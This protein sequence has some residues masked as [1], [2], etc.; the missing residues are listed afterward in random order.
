MLV[1]R[2]D[3]SIDDVVQLTTNNLTFSIEAH[4]EPPELKG[5]LTFLQIEELSY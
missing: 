5:K 1:V 3:S 4:V 2:E